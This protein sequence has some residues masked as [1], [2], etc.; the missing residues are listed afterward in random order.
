MIVVEN[1]QLLFVSKVPGRGT[2]DNYTAMLPVMFAG[3]GN[4]DITIISFFFAVFIIPSLVQNE[5]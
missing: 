5:G 1:F 2:P 3:D 4:D